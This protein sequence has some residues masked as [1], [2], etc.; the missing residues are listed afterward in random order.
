[1]RRF[2]L[3]R[4]KCERRGGSRQ[5][6]FRTNVDDVVAAGRSIHCALRASAPVAGLKPYVLV[7]GRLEALLTRA[8]LHDLAEL[9]VRGERATASRR[10]HVERRDILPD[11]VPLPKRSVH[12]ELGPDEA[13]LGRREQL[14]V[15]TVTLNSLPS[16]FAVQKS[17]K[18]LSLGKRG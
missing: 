10:R 2:S 11:S 9:A 15:A 18:P 17:R 7:R 1:M 8:L 13:H 4:W 16:S 12:L 3:W 14:A 5:L 6:V